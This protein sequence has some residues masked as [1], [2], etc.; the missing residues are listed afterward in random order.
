MSIVRT[1]PAP[2]AGALHEIVL[3]ALPHP[4]LTI[5]PNGHV[6][7]ANVA[8]EAFFESGL[9][10]LR[11]QPLKDFVPFGSPL[12]ALIEQVRNSTGPVNEY[13]VD[14]GTPRNGGERLAD[15]HVAPL[16]ERPR[17]RRRRD[18]GAQHGRQDRPP[19]HAPRRRALRHGA[20]FDARA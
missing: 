14:L 12:I 5:A 11:R 15:I 2:N 9:Q 7:E 6:L 4:V 17:P 16:Q 10:M 19:A 3:N 1:K 8:A 13:R 20:R 18:A